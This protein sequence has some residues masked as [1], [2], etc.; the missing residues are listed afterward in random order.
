MNVSA[1][2]TSKVPNASPTAA[3]SGSDING[4]AAREAARELRDAA[5]G[6]R[7]AQFGCDPGDVT[8]R[9][10]VVAGGGRSM[11]FAELRDAAYHAR[12][13]LSATGFYATPKIHY[14]RKTLPAGRSSTTRTA[15]R[16]PR[17]RSTR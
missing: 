5:R 1:S 8:F 15:R 9:D 13:P 16:A 6:V 11:S 4:M 3:S 12:V 10:G 17:S 2:D 7:R 14:D